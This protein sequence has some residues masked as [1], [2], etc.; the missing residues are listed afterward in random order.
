[1]SRRSDEASRAASPV[2]L[3][4]SPGLSVVLVILA[5]VRSLVE[6]H[7]SAQVLTEPSLSVTSIRM[8]ECGLRH[9]NSFTTPSIST[10]WVES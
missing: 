9:T 10:F 7:S 4:L 5:W 2:T 6:P 8:K 1:M 3:S